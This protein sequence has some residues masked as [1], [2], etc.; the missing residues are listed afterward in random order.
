[1]MGSVS[2][3]EG[4]WF[5]DTPV[6]PMSPRRYPGR[7]DLHRCGYRPGSVEGTT[8]TTDKVIGSD[9]IS[10]TLQSVV[11]IEDKQWRLGTPR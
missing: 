10:L 2:C 6:R 1:M 5:S 8:C 11:V 3:Q 7:W 9:R 4:Q